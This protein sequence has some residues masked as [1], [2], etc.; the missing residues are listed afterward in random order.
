MAASACREAA[1]RPVVAVNPAAKCPAV[2]RQ[3]VARQAVTLQAATPLQVECPVVVHQVVECPAVRKVLECRRAAC[4]VVTLAVRL[5]KGAL[6]AVFQAVVSA[7]ALDVTRRAVLASSQVIRIVQSS[8]VK[9]LIS[10]SVILMK[11]SAKNSDRCRRLVETR[12]DLVTVPAVGVDPSVW[13][14]RKLGRQVAVPVA[15]QVQVLALE[16]RPAAH[17][18][19]RARSMV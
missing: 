3:V 19:R 1:D 8:W 18:A 2:A 7:A 13:A 4:P 16:A 6:T 5:G 11:R 10:P 14:S 9:S 17:K 12:K 15:V